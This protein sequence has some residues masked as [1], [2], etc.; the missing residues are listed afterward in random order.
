MFCYR[1][2]TRVSIIESPDSYRVSYTV[3]LYWAYVQ[4]L[5]P[6]TEPQI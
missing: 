1:F 2:C 3:Y 5:K 4:P 6:V